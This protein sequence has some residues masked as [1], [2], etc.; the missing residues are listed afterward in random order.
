VDAHILEY[1]TKYQSKDSFHYLAELV[2]FVNEGVANTLFSFEIYR[3][4]DLVGHGRE[5]LKKG[6]FYMYICLFF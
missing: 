6:F 5:T 3:G 4:N 1:V 2:D